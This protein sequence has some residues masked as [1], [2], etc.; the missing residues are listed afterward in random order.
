MWYF[1]A[2]ILALFHSNGGGGTPEEEKVPNVGPAIDLLLAD[3][4]DG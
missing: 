3:E 1:I 2:G 4:V